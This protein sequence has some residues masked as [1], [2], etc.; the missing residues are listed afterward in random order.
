MQC[1][2]PAADMERSLR[3]VVEDI[4][5]KSRWG[6]SWSSAPLVLGMQLSALKQGVPKSFF[7]RTST[8]AENESLRAREI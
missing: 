6:V 8:C 4:A 7:P 1:E 2:K 5:D 3:S